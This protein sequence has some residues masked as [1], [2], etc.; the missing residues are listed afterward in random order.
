VLAP[1]ATFT[2]FVLGLHILGVVAG[3]GVTFAYPI[4][5]ASADAATARV[6]RLISQRLVNPSLVLILVCGIYLAAKEHQFGAFYV[7]WGF[8]AVIVLGGMEGAFMAPRLKALAAGGTDA[9]GAEPDALRQVR[10][11][12]ALQSLIVVLTVFFMATHAGG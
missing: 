12:G 6:L 9:G 1:A 10:L 11:G 3:F 5:L 7:Q 2:D 4:L 8:A